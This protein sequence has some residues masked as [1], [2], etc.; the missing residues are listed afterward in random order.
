MDG[1]AEEIAELV[2]DAVSLAGSGEVVQDHLA[3]RAE[4][5]LGRASHRIGNLGS[6]ILKRL[7]IGRTAEDTAPV[8]AVGLLRVRGHFHEPRFDHHLLGRLVD[9]NQELFDPVDIRAGLAIENRIRPLIDLRR[10]LAGEL[11]SD[12]RHGLLRARIAELVAVAFGRLGRAFRRRLDVVNVVDL[13]EEQA[14]CFHD[15]RDRLERGDVF[16]T[17]RYRARDRFADDH[18]DLG[19]AREEP[20]NRAHI[21]TL[22]F[23]NTDAAIVRDAVW[24]HRTGRRGRCGRGGGVSGCR[25]ARGRRGSC[26]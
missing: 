25:R 16:Q 23:A 12:Q 4:L 24:F 6:A 17:H 13:I 11:P 8:D 22:K 10:V 7:R 18:I 26:V 2:A 19:L 1:V 20:Q 9:L 3:V 21:V 14:F 15:N 5:N